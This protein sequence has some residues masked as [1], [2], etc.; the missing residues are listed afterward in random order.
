MKLTPELDVFDPEL[1]AIWEIGQMGGRT[2]LLDKEILFNNLM[3]VIE[4][5]WDFGIKYWISHGTMLGLYRDGDFITQDDDADIGADMKD[6][7]KALA[8]EE[9]LRRRGFYVPQQGDP[10]KPVDSK[11]NMPYSDTVAIRDGEK[12]EIWWYDKVG[13]KYVYDLRRPPAELSHDEKY[14]DG[15]L[16]VINFKHGLVRVPNHLEE[17]LVMMYGSDWK[18]PQAG[19]KYNNTLGRYR[20]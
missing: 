7:H 17:W 1:N 11:S 14:Y 2:R 19:V 9:E 8:M 15:E 12:V 10:L 18:I 5:F 20:K 16:D 3:E 6:K 4:V 13:D